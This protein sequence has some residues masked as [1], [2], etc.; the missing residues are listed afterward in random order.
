MYSDIVMYGQDIGRRWAQTAL[1]EQLSL[2]AIMASSAPTISPRLKIDISGWTNE[3]SFA[4]SPNERHLLIGAYNRGWIIELET[5]S[6]VWEGVEFR[7]VSSLG[8]GG[9][10]DQFAIAECRN[11]ADDGARRSPSDSA[12]RCLNGEVHLYNFDGE[13]ADLDFSRRLPAH[14][15]LLMAYD[16]GN[17]WSVADNGQIVLVSI[18]EHV[19]V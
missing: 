11:F 14:R 18:D 8:W 16:G 6:V 19:T 9:G 1:V 7:A 12:G 5:G 3:F 4:L 2:R 17:L 13:Q 10:G 15:S